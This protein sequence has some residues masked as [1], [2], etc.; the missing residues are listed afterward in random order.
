[1][2]PI[3]SQ[4]LWVTLAVLPL[5]RAAA[6]P[7]AVLTLED[8]DGKLRAGIGD[9][10][11]CP[12]HPEAPALSPDYDPAAVFLEVVKTGG[13]LNKGIRI[14]ANGMEIA[15]V[16]LGKMEFG[17]ARR[18]LGVLEG[19]R[20]DAVRQGKRLAVDLDAAR[21]YSSGFLCR[22]FDMDESKLFASILAV[23]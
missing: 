7:D 1:M 5:A 20:A 8:A 12:E 15:L 22:G 16:E 14:R 4:I 2:I 13:W 6:A 3:R 10:R 9:Q 19:K 18:F 21:V 11:L 17:P 23:R